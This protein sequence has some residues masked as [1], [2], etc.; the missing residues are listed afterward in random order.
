MTIAVLTCLLL[1]TPL[2]AILSDG[3][4]TTFVQKTMLAVLEVITIAD[5]KGKIRRFRS[6]SFIR[7][8][9]MRNPLLSYRHPKILLNGLLWQ[10]GPDGKIGTMIAGQREEGRARCQAD[11]KGFADKPAKVNRARPKV[12]KHTFEQAALA[13][14]T[15]HGGWQNLT[16]IKPAGEDAL[17]HQE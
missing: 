7:A 10:A 16:R 14:A 8:R 11:S 5:G 12:R 17:R 3:H 2:P 9:R 1:Q 13:K 6:V 15:R 4:S